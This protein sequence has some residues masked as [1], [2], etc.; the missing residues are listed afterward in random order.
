MQS[1]EIT[2]SGLKRRNVSGSKSNSKIS[3]KIR[4]SIFSD[5]GVINN[6]FGGSVT[7]TVTKGKPKSI[8]TQIRHVA[9]GLVGSGGV[10]KV[11]DKTLHSK[12][13]GTKSCT[14]SQSHRYVASVAYAT[15][16][17]EVVIKYSGGT[18][19]VEATKYY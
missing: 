10:G 12:C 13:N 4:G 17:A 14:N 18:L 2:T 6:S 7:A 1:G 16:Y 11:Q 19:K 9:F 15:T 5:I 8:D 3:A